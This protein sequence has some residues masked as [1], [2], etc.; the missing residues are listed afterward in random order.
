[1]VLLPRLERTVTQ[2]DLEQI[3][4]RLASALAE[5]CVAVRLVQTEHGGCADFDVE[6][7]RALLA[8]IDELEDKNLT[9]ARQWAAAI[10]ELTARLAITDKALDGAAEEI[11]ALTAQ[12]RALQSWAEGARTD[13]EAL[14]AQRDKV[15][16]LHV[17]WS[18]QRSTITR[19]A[20]C[21]KPWPCETVRALGVE[22]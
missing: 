20:V 2:P 17:R 19:C 4:Q 12:L 16:A 22:Q 7:L 18:P 11:E 3:K 6:Q 1:M 10:D 21:K 15:L 14:T 5:P 13:L 8:A 9:L